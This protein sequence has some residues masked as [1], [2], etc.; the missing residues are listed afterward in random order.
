M[1]NAMFKFSAALTLAAAATSAAYAGGFMLTEQSVAGLG[2]AYAGSGIVGDDLSAVWYNPAGMV[3]LPGTQFQMG[4]VMAYLDLDVETNKGDTDNGA[5]HGVPI[6]N[7]FFTHQMNEDMWFGFG[8]TVPFGMATEYKRDWELADHGMNAEVKVFDFNPNVAWKVNDKLSIGA[9]MSL[10]YVTAQF[11]S[12][13]AI[14]STVHTMDHGDVKVKAGQTRV[15]L[16]AD[17]WAWGGN[18]GFMWQPTEKVRVGL[19]YRS[20]VNHKADGYL[21]TDV[22]LRGQTTPY[23]TNDGHAEMSGPHT[24]TLTGTWKATDALRLSGLV[25]WAN[26]SSFDKLPISGTSLYLASYNANYAAAKAQHNSDADAAAYAQSKASNKTAPEYHWKDS[27]LFTV[28]ADY[29]INEQVTVR[30]GVG[31]EISPVDDDK[32]RSATIP[33]TDRL[34][35]SLGATWRVNKQLQGDFGIAYLKGIGN[36][37]LYNEESGEKLG[38]F[39]RLDAILWGAQF[40]YKFD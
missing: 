40:V 4:S 31:Y 25:R 24:I 34:W 38:E 8:I 5:K 33:D 18:L 10:Q 37:G 30:G 2:R 29:D 23:K 36:K 14:Y 26:W 15:R 7:M 11:E 32:Y 27:W 19:A 9:G 3:L 21:K 6:P 35:L 13:K 16:N 17:G 28:G 20:Q 12:T 22:T 39:D 1:K